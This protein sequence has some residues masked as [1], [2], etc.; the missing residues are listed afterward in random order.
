MTCFVDDRRRDGIAV[1]R[2]AKHHGRRDRERVTAGRGEQS[3]RWRPLDARAGRFRDA[4]PAGVHR[5][6]SAPAAPARPAVEFHGR[7]SELPAESRHATDEPAIQNHAAAET[8]ARRQHDERAH[9][10]AGAEHPFAERQRVHVVVDE[11][12]QPEPRAE[13]LPEREAGELRHVGHVIV[14]LARHRIDRAGNADAGAGDREPV[15]RRPIAHPADHLGDRVFRVAGAT[16]RRFVIG[17]DDG[18]VRRDDSSGDRRAADVD[19][20]DRGAA[21]G[22][23]RPASAPK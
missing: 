7:V 17:D 4:A 5:E 22:H 20:D 16:R 1:F 11:H 23:Q 19:A 14:D 9:A 8:G 3:G 12:R 10:A 15:T 6:T 13:P 2:G 21:A 18:S